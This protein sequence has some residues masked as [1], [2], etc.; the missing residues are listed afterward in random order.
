MLRTPMM[1]RSGSISRTIRRAGAASASG[2]PAVRRMRYMAHWLPALT[3]GSWSC[4][5]KISGGTGSESPALR[6][7]RATPTMVIH[8]RLDEKR[9]CCPTGLALG[10]NAR[11][12]VSLMIATGSD[13]RSSCG[14]KTRPCTNPMDMA[15]KYSR[16]T[17][18]T[19]GDGAV[20]S[21]AMVRPSIRM[22]LKRF[23]SANRRDDLAR[24]GVPAFAC[25]LC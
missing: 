20:S 12:D 18:R 9:T 13:A 14:P 8:G 2:S 16:V 24:W 6:T 15:R 7:S 21:G 1:A 11:A 10:Q 17:N 23:R 19:L 22:S 25:S 3:A 5:R 4:S